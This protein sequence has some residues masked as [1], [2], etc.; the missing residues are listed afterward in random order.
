MLL[1]LL[2]LDED[3]DSAKCCPSRA[4]LDLV[5]FRLS[6]NDPAKSITNQDALR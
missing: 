5:L 1:L 4:I 3:E 6:A 2:L